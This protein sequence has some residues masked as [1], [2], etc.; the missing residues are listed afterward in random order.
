MLVLA[1]ISL[2]R[3]KE[4]NTY[5]NHYDTTARNYQ[6]KLPLVFGKWRLLKETLRFDR[7][8]SL[9]DYLFLDKSEILSLSVSLGG[10]KEIYDN[11][12]AA[13]LRTISKFSMIYNEGIHALRSV[14]Y[15]KKWIHDLSINLK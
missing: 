7:F 6:E 4:A 1:T 9:P 10:N 15:P 11:I 14:D 2:K 5:I 13:G 8:P 3:R 12:R